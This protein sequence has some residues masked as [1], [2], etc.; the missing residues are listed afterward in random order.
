M[1]ITLADFAGIA[2]RVDARNLP[3]NAAQVATNTKLWRGV[4]QPFRNYASTA[5]INR[6][7]PLST[8]YRFGASQPETQYWW[9]F[10]G[11]VNVVRGPVA[12]DTTERTYYTGVGAP[13]ATDN[14]LA[15]TGGTTYPVVSYALG[16]PKPTNVP[17]ATVS[18]TLTGTSETRIYVYTFVSTW[19]EEGKPSGVSNAVEAGDGQTV[20]LAGMSVSP[21]A[22]ITLKRIY[23]SATG[24][25]SAGY[26]FVEE[27]PAAQTTY[28]DTKSAT[29]LGETITSLYNDEP[30]SNMVGLTAMPG[31]ILAGFTGNTLCF[32]ETG[33]PHAWPRKYEISTEYDIV[34]LG[35][36]G[37]SLAVLTKGAPYIVTGID[38]AA[39]SMQRMELQQA[40]VSKRSIVQ[41]GEAVMYASP[42]GIVSVGTQGVQLLT[43]KLFTRDDWQALKP[44]TIHAYYHEGRYVGFY[45]TGT[46]QAGFVLDVFNRQFYKLNFYPTAGFNDLVNDALFLCFGTTVN[47]FEGSTSN[48]SYTW[49]SKKF[50]LPAPT[51][52]SCLMAVADTYPFTVNVCPELESSAQASAL[53][54]KFPG[55][56]TVESGA[57]VKYSASVTG[58][59]VIRLP[60]GFRAKLWEFEVIGAS[61][62][63]QVH[64]STSVE[65]LKAR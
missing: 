52:F 24:N 8:I 3:D 28:N 27:I 22:N 13:K 49:R 45:D 40:C 34:G 44:E 11:D 31:S 15:L 46:E 38:P 4:L 50:V 47:K 62:V 18:G 55:V 56:W 9:G 63:Q 53:A 25:S 17:T 64:I 5:T 19:G 6:T 26:Q 65:E 7:G 23:R 10:T 37:T 57:R 41:L 35:V 61:T 36:M 20:A 14:G 16:I 48:L 30:R 51:N 21:A 42:D 58:P 39:M 59:G 60:S 1:L 12:G 32:S 43:E 33:L 54:A 29:A 2:P